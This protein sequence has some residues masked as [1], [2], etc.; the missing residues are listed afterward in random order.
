MSALTAWPIVGDQAPDPAVLSVAFEV[1]HEGLAVVECGRI[2]YANPVFARALGCSR[3]HELEGKPLA[4]LV[5]KTPSLAHT[6]GESFHLYGREFTVLSLRR[7]PRARARRSAGISEA[8]T[9]GRLVSGVAHDFNNLLTGILLYCDLLSSSLEGNPQ[10]QRQVKEMRAAGEQGGAMIQQLL[11]LARHQVHAPR[12][13][14]W[15]DTVRSMQNFLQRLIGEHIELASELAP[16]LAPV[17]MDPAQMQQ[18]VLNLVLNARDAL[19]DGG[20][21]LLATR[22]CRDGKPRAGERETVS[23]VEFMVADNGCGMDPQTRARIFEPF[24]T[25][26]GPGRGNGLG[27]STVHSIVAQHR[28]TIQVESVPG[29]GTRVVVHLPALPASKFKSEPKHEDS[30]K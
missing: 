16:D 8:E 17:E 13:L 9:I 27:L 19:A 6:F 28:G 5:A 3:D 10:V 15:N 24:F 1:C 22:N 12:P 11:T 14:S 30:R 29:E 25:T 26:K 2:V 23:A 7:R 21:V 20:R 18:V 4:Q